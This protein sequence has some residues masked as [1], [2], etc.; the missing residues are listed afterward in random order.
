M[1][2]G[3]DYQEKW[4]K[5]SFIEDEGLGIEEFEPDDAFMELAGTSAETD[6]RE[7][8]RAD[9]FKYIFDKEE[10]P[11]IEGLRKLTDAAYEILEC[12]DTP[13]HTPPDYNESLELCRDIVKLFNMEI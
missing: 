7:S 5:V 1:E 6:Y 12:S 8:T 10:G 4:I 13:P 2:Y 11:A 9:I 3:S